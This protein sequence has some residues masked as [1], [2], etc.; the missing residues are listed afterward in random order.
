MLDEIKQKIAIGKIIIGKFKICDYNRS[1][2]L[3]STILPGESNLHQLQMRCID[4]QPDLVGGELRSFKT[5][6]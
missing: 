3:S 1:S 5:H 6:F 4:V 2:Q